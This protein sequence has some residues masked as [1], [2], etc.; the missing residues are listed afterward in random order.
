MSRKLNEIDLRAIDLNLFVTLD[1]LVEAR[2][3][4]RAAQRLHL[5][6]SAV[7]MA[8]ARLRDL[9]GDPLLVRTPAGMEPT[10]RALAVMRTVRP[11]LEAMRSAVR[12]DDGFDPATSERVVRFAAPD[13]LE[14]VLVPALLETLAEGAPRLRLISRPADF[15]TVAALLDRAEVDVALIAAPRDLDRR[16]LHDVLYDERLVCLFDPARVGRRL[17]LRRFLALPQVLQSTSGTVRSRLDD[18]L[19]RA[20]HARHV[21]AAVAH[22]A[23]LPLILRRI[24]AVA[25]MPA[26][27]AR[28]L[29]RDH[30]LAI[31][32]LPIASPRFPVV[33][34]WSARVARDPCIA[35][36]RDLLRAHV[37][38][39]IAVRS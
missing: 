4:R 9:L 21:I 6:P 30:G 29:A 24:R 7:S 27:P 35:W 34:A 28:H 15:Q 23:T 18:A 17:D 14:G 36:F 16:I 39:I 10:P 20:G 31:R 3:V 12:E 37:R 1:A 13:D 32:E 22:F 8:L 11:A 2:S 38:S 25:C 26:V 19:A 33:L 5:T